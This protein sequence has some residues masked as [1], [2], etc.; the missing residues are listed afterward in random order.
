[1]SCLLSLSLSLSAFL[2]FSLSKTHYLSMTTRFPASHLTCLHRFERE[3]RTSGVIASRD[4]IDHHARVSLLRSQHDRPVSKVHGLS[5]GSLSWSR[6][7]APIP[8]TESERKW[9]E[10]NREN[11]SLVTCSEAYAVEIREDIA[12]TCEMFAEGSGALNALNLK[13]EYQSGLSI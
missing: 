8:S 12:R 2:S 7:Q 1:M 9:G 6:Y 3:H 10:S 5:H 4:L 11:E 13:L